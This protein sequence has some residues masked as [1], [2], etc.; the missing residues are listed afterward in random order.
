[1]FMMAER[2]ADENGAA[3]SLFKAEERPT[4]D[5]GPWLWAIE[6]LANASRHGGRIVS[7]EFEPMVATG[8]RCS[9]TVAIS[10]IGESGL[11]ERNM[12][13]VEV[14]SLR[15]DPTEFDDKGAAR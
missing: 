9:E 14:E 13:S 7:V 15:R 1:M 12:L 8:E 5:Q 6:L 3:W 11:G 2:A 10:Q 4:V